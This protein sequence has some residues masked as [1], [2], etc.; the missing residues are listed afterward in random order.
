MASKT[1]HRGAPELLAAYLRG[2]PGSSGLEPNR[3]RAIPVDGAC[4]EKGDVRWVDGARGQRPVSPW[5]RIR[6]AVEA[7]TRRTGRPP[8]AII[9]SELERASLLRGMQWSGRAPNL[10]SLPSDAI[11]EYQGVQVL[12]ASH[13]VHIE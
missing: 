6:E 1:P 9:L 11:F 5:S 7:H 13:C 8:L 12:C 4:A 10:W 2:R 3:H